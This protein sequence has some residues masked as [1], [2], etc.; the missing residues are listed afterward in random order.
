M[1]FQLDC[2]AVVVMVIGCI[3]CCIYGTLHRKSE[4]GFYNHYYITVVCSV[5]H[6]SDSGTWFMLVN[7]QSTT[8][9]QSLIGWLCLNMGLLLL[10]YSHTF[11]MA[12]QGFE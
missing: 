12:G 8:A 9:E 6:L 4:S 2:R 3:Y 1:S 11:E 5:W 10:I 7:I